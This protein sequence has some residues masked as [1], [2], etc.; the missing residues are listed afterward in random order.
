MRKRLLKAVKED[1]KITT[2]IEESEEYQLILTCIP[3]A[4]YIIRSSII[5]KEIRLQ[6]RQKRLQEKESFTVR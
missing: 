4:D 1:Q 3:I 6:K 5:L 2:K